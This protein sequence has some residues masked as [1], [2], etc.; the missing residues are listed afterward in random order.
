[1]PAS[2]SATE[3]TLPEE[4]SQPLRHGAELHSTCASG[5]QKIIDKLIAQ[6]PRCE[7]TNPASS[8]P[9]PQTQPEDTKNQLPADELQQTAMADAGVGNDDARMPASGSA[10]Q[11]TLPEEKRQPLRHGAE[12]HSAAKELQQG[13]DAFLDQM[14]PWE[15]T[16]PAS[17]AATAQ[18]QPEDKKQQLPT[19]EL[20]QTELADAAVEEYDETIAD[21]GCDTKQ[22]LLETQ[23][24]QILPEDT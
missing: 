14:P 24:T 19:E 9:K 21:W 1:M 5:L 20:Q 4:K 11:Q 6:R 12:L 3:Q 13:F 8:S 7:L 10:T 16:E 22:T 18:T 2:G 15:L 23:E 17:G